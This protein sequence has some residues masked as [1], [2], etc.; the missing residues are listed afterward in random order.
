MISS[1]H[2]S[3]RIN[4]A[5]AGDIID[6][7]AVS[8]KEAAAFVSGY[9]LRRY[10]PST[11]GKALPSAQRAKIQLLATQFYGAYGQRTDNDAARFALGIGEGG[12][13]A[14]IRTAFG[15]LFDVARAGGD[16]IRGLAVSVLE[17]AAALLGALG[18]APAAE[19]FARAAGVSVEQ[20]RNVTTTLAQ[21]SFAL[22]DLAAKTLAEAP[23][24]LVSLPIQAALALKTQVGAAATAAVNMGASAVGALR[25]AGAQ[26]FNT[27]V[28]A[29]KGLAAAGESRVEALL[30]KAQTVAEKTA[31]ALTAAPAALID[32]IQAKG[33]AALTAIG[34]EVREELK[35]LVDMGTAPVK[36]AAAAVTGLLTTAGETMGAAKTA[37]RDLVGTVKD[38]G[39]S[40]V[41]LVEAKLSDGAKALL[42]MKSIGAIGVGLAAL[43][44]LL[45][46]V[47]LFRG[48]TPALLRG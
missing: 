22:L 41:K 44:A 19:K 27:A 25:D 6:G 1:T 17:H 39:A 12:A 48:R 36:A 23:A 37:A 46:A 40:G 5:L 26:A 24:K 4:H 31:K 47:F 34:K 9:L 7:G 2:L 16:S 33:E 8:P 10:L 42:G 13:V 20:A 30:V 28:A 21:K 18:E 15:A 3:A 35:T 11:R 43:L 38:A 29:A 32:T 14:G 45:L